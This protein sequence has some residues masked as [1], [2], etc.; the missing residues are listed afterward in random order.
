MADPVP[1]E[2]LLAAPGPLAPGP[3]APEPGPDSENSSP[4][5][6]PLRL[7]EPPLRVSS[8]EDRMSSSSS[9]GGA[10]RNVGFDRLGDDIAVSLIDFR[11][12]L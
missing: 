8:P 2:T 12:L 3:K 6:S 9:D 7:L 1:K 5:E 10:M 4:D 11:A